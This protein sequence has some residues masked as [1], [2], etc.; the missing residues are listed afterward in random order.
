M[1]AEGQSGKMTSDMEVYMKQ[2]CATEFLY[3]EKIAS[4][5]IHH[6]LPNDYGDPTV[7][8]ST[9]RQGVVQLSGGNSNSWSPPLVQIF[10]KCGMQVLAH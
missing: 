8:V 1:A 10:Y 4:I 6:H 7:D 2:R 5:D 9:V 3:V